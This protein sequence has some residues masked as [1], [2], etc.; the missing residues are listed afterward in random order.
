METNVQIFNNPRF[1]CSVRI[2]TDENN[3]PHFCLKDICSALD[4]QSAAVVRRLADGVTTNHPIVDNL[5]RQQVAVFVNEDGLYDVILDSRKS[6]AK[7]F[8]KWITSEVL[9]TIRKHGAYMTDNVLKEALT[10]PDFGIQLLTELK[11]E[12]QA[13][14]ELQA[15]A[16]QQQT[17]I[18]EQKLQIADMT[19]K[20]LYCEMVLSA[21][22]LVK[23]TDIA[24]DYGT[25]AEAFNAYLEM[26]HIQYRHKPPQDM[27]NAKKKGQ[28]ILYEPWKSKGYVHSETF[29]H[30]HK[31]GTI[32]TQRLTKWTQEG[33]LFLYREL[34]KHNALPVVEW[35][36]DY[37]MPY[38]LMSYAARQEYDKRQKQIVKDE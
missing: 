20:S 15:K 5:G 9:P 33:C 34:K 18:A 30:K 27:P 22:S 17:V 10:N 6:E 2:V 12:R 36:D 14:L 38:Y 37:Q 21:R 29:P 4:L 35:T 11:N 13:R 32:E 7:A 16:A 24:Q 19:E 28:W 31:D 25:T 1:T 8:R 3:E 23:V 26:L